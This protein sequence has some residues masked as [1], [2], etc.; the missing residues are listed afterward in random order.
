MSKI[1]RNTLRN[2]SDAG[3]VLNAGWAAMQQADPKLAAAVQKLPPSIAQQ[4]VLQYTNAIRSGKEAEASVLATQAIRT[5]LAE[6]TNQPGASPNPK[7]K[8]LSRG[9]ANPYD[10]SA[11]E[12]DLNQPDQKVMRGFSSANSKNEAMQQNNQQAFA[13][14]KNKYGAYKNNANKE[15]IWQQ[16]EVDLSAPKDWAPVVPNNL[17]A[18]NPYQD[19]GGM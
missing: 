15:L 2:S 10:L 18:P 14:V 11:F 13:E 1:V 16:P 19:S 17:N 8:I 3:E 4:A 12:S 6:T 9:A 7:P 5:Q